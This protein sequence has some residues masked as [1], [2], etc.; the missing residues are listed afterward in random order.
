M[1]K[2]LIGG[3]VVSVVLAGFLFGA[4]PLGVIDCDSWWGWSIECLFA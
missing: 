4:Q 3:V 1:R 2:R